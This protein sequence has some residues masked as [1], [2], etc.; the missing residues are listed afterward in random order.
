MSYIPQTP[1]CFASH[2]GLW[3]MET[4]AANARYTA[5]RSGLLAADTE[6]RDTSLSEKVQVVNGI[7]AIPVSG[8]MMRGSS[9][10]D[11]G[12]STVALRKEVARAN[13]DPQINGIALIIDSPG[14]HVSGMEELA[15]DLSSSKLPIR[16]YIQDMGASAAY[17]AAA[18]TESI[19]ISPMGAAGSLGVYAVLQDVSK[20]LEDDGVELTVV[21]TGDHKGL[22]ADGK[23]TPELVA[24][25][26]KRVDF[27]NG[28]FA[29][30]VSEGRGFDAEKGASLQTGEMFNAPEALANGLVDSI[31]TIEGFLNTFAQEVA[32]KKSRSTQARVALARHRR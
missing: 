9:K 14:G 26:Q 13:K 19:T 22:G 16:S 24:S 29:K 21:S 11:E 12:T 7:A 20:A 23:V 3:A 4:T 31:D 6:F 25:V 28:F 2:M 15:S 1:E 5:I 17:W 32:P 30:A 10:F 27:V 8:V 18:S